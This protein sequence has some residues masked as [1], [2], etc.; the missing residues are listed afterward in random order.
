MHGNYLSYSQLGCLHMYHVRA[1]SHKVATNRYRLTPCIF[2]PFVGLTARWK[3]N[4]DPAVPTNMEV[5]NNWW[6]NYVHNYWSSEGLNGP[7]SGFV[8]HALLLL[9]KFVS[10]INGEE[11]VY[12]NRFVANRLYTEV[13]SMIQ[14]CVDSKGISHHWVYII[15]W[16]YVIIC[17]KIKKTRFQTLPCH[18]N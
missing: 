8:K 4:S 5:G 18:N 12:M 10:E 16:R 1:I 13:L 9:H 7:C 2:I 17:F 14:C 11:M 15:S 3:S 6:H